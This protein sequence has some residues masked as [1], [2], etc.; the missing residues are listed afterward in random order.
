MCVKTY[1]PDV[2]MYIFGQSFVFQKSSEDLEKMLNRDMSE[3]SMVWMLFF[4]VSGDENLEEM[5]QILDKQCGEYSEY[6]DSTYIT[7]SAYYVTSCV[8]L[9]KCVLKHINQT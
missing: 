6:F 8:C 7:D 1:K 3:H 5:L 4:G 2:I 9:T